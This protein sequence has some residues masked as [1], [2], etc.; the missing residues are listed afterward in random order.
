MMHVFI[1]D[2][3]LINLISDTNFE[4]YV[5]CYETSL[6]NLDSFENNI[7]RCMSHCRSFFF[8]ITEVSSYYQ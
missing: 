5:G 6:S 1:N 3:N 2:V 8:G 7:Y 4:N